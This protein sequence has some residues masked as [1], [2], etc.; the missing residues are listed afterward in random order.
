M[1]LVDQGRLQILP[2]SGHAT[3]EA[4]VAPARCCSR[5]FKSCVYAVGNKAKLRSSRHPNRRSRVVRQHVDRRVIRW[6]VAPPALPTVVR[7]W[8]TE[9]TE[10]ITP[11]D[12]GADSGKTLR[13]N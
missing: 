4:D 8:A 5:L 7:P 11:K 9:R 3:T 12:P 10:H 13:R 2:N 6:L 1:Q